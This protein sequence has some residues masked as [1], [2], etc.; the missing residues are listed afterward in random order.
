GLPRALPSGMLPTTPSV[1]Q[2][3]RAQASSSAPKD[4]G[5]VA[6]VRTPSDAS[7]GSPSLGTLSQS[8]MLTSAPSLPG[9]LGPSQPKPAPPAKTQASAGNGTPPLQAGTDTL[10]RYLRDNNVRF[11][12]TVLGPVSV[13]VFRSTQYKTPVVVSLGQDL[14]DTKITLTDLRGHEAVFT[15]NDSTQSLSLDLRR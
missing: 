3:T 5:T 13:G 6:A 10:S 11:T 2:S 9:V 8:G 14:P 1:L 4:L 7:N 12:G 15:L